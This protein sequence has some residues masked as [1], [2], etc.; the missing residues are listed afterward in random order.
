MRRR[1]ALTCLI[2]TFLLGLIFSTNA[3]TTLKVSSKL[4]IFGGGGFYQPGLKQLN[5]GMKSIDNLITTEGAATLQNFKRLYTDSVGIFAT[6]LLDFGPYQRK[7]A[8]I[9]SLDGK[10]YYDFGIRYFLRPD[11]NLTLTAGYFKSESNTE[12]FAEKSS[13]ESTWPWL[14]SY[15]SDYMTVRQSI[16][17]FPVQMT[18]N[19]DLPFRLLNEAV[20]FYAGAGVGYQFSQIVLDIEKQFQ[21]AYNRSPRTPFTQ[22]TN[23]TLTPHILSNIRANVNPFGGQ[24]LLGVKVNYSIFRLGVEVGYNFATAKIDEKDWY[25]HSQKL[26]LTQ[27]FKG[28]NYSETS[29]AY[30]TIYDESRKYLFQN[31]EK[32]FETLKIKELDLSG[33]IIKG[34][35]GLAF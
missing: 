23:N 16:K 34:S 21:L 9:G 17:S 24:A 22:F 3:Q 20:N 6:E 7:S 12:Y 18:L 15:A 19:Y 28:E 5:D 8:K 32:A 4:E 31:G 2:L 25:F 13:S 11:L 30:V 10:L 1:I 26:T 29:Q 27:G 35:L 33:L 14:N